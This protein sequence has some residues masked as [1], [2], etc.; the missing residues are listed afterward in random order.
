MLHVY[1]FCSFLRYNARREK[2]DKCERSLCTPDESSESTL[3]SQTLHS[4]VN[5]CEFLIVELIKFLDSKLSCVVQCP[6]VNNMY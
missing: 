6:S 1:L 4:H 5:V 3:I 2:A